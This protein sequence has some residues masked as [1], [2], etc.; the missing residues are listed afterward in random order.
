MERGDKYKGASLRVKINKKRQKLND[1]LS[2]DLYN[3][4]YA[5]KT[6]EELD[7]LIVQYYKN[8][9]GREF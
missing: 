4:D 6:S 2:K 1:I 5:Q 3:K 8:K 7:D 9:Y